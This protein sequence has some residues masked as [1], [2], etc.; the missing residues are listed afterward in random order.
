[1][2]GKSE[3]KPD[4][5]DL[6]T[7]DGPLIPVILRL[8]GPAVLMMYLQGAYNIIDTI[9]VGRL[10]GNV[11]LAGIATG[12]FV[13]WSI[14][15]LTSL[16]SVGIMAKLARRIGENDLQGAELIATRG[17]WY[18]F[19]LS[20]VIGA[21]LWFMVPSLFRLMGTDPQVT[22][23]GTG[24][25]RV[26]L[27][28][29]PFIFLSFTLQRIFQAVGDTVT[30]MW[31]MFFTLMINTV[32][33]PVLMLGMFGFPR[34]GVAG[35]ALATVIARLFMVASGIW[36]LLGKK[37]IS[38]KPLPYPLLRNLPHAVP[39]ITKGFIGLRPGE[40]AG[41]DWKLFGSMLA[42]GLPGAVSQILFPLVYMIITRLP[43]SYG[44]EYIAALRIGHTVEGI[45]FFLAFG[46]SIATATCL[47]QNLGAQ[48]ADRAARSGWIA[49]GIVVLTLFVFSVFFFIFPRQI[50]TV[51][52]SEPN[53]IEASAAYLK[54]LAVSQIFM[55]IEIVLSGAFSGAGDTLPPMAITVPIN[56]ARIP[57]A[58]ILA[59][60]VGLGI[61][62]V[63]WAI[64]GTS[65]L[66]G[67]AMAFWFSRGGWKRK[68]V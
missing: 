19:V 50:G 9:W 64:S 34:L 35:A 62:G 13:L 24:Y 28:G 48:K 30:P 27:V 20:L 8:A 61:N 21:A 57:L 31:L 4:I 33:D 29:C 53:A 45:S 22:A 41:W 66:K 52:S 12:G 14:F 17:L 11:A 49:T 59:E 25:L 18:A 39:T 37:R 38:T 23:Q 55:G 63:W 67:L 65:I 7:G 26:L 46:F 54:I 10:L 68:K 5:Q 32:L 16:V 51:F 36:L 43:A 1:M 44:P 40:V 6:I 42:I 60:D 58:Y 47:G 3:P 15:G 56:L 2:H